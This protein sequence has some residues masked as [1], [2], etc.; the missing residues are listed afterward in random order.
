MSE[1]E[2]EHIRMMIEAVMK[3]RFRPIYLASGLIVTIFLAVAGVVFNVA[4]SQSKT[5]SSKEAYRNFLPKEQYH[6]LQKREHNCDREAI[7]NPAQSEYIYM[8]HN[9]DEAENLGIMYRGGNK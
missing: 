9:M 8:K 5:I 7:S 6:I 3:R 4:I 1:S 2:K